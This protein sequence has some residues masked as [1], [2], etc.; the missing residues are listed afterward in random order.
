MM[1]ATEAPQ[2]GA[3]ERE[4]VV[5]SDEELI[6]RFGRAFEGMLAL[7]EA[8]RRIALQAESDVAFRGVGAVISKLAE[9]EAEAAERA[10]DYSILV[11]VALHRWLPEE[12]RRF[13]DEVIRANEPPGLLERA[14]EERHLRFARHDSLRAQHRQN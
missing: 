4:L 9:L 5:A 14:L 8:A 7:G 2:L 10:D 11:S 6:R 12:Y 13:D 1:T 3:R